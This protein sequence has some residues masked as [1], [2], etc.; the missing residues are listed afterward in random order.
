[1]LALLSLFAF[2]L[3]RVYYIHFL[4]SLIE[5][6]YFNLFRILSCWCIKI[7]PF[8]QRNM[9]RNVFFTRWKVSPNELA[10]LQ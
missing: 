6:G 10:A 1:M 8:M 7:R 5:R 2:D 4:V 3:I 9:N